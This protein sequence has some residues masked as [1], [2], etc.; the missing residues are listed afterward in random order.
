MRVDP[1]FVSNLVNSLDLTQASE[2]QLTAELSSGVRVNSLSQ[3]PIASGENGLRASNV[4]SSRAMKTDPPLP[5]LIL[6]S[7]R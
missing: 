4:P 1:Y 2:Q 7:R 5:I 6:S 3:D